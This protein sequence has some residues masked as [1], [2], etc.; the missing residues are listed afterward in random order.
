METCVACNGSGRL[1]REACPLC[2]GVIGWPDQDL[3][4]VMAAGGVPTIARGGMPAEGISL[5]SWNLLSPDTIGLATKEGPHYSHLTDEER[6][7][8]HRWPKILEEIRIADATVVCLQEI[9]KG[10]F[11]EIKEALA[12]FG[13][14]CVTHKKMQRNSLAIFFKPSFT[15]VWEV[16]PKIKGFEKTLAVGLEDA[17]RVIAVVICH[18]EGHPEKS[19]ERLAQLEKTFAEIKDLPHQAL[20]V[21][22]DFNAPLVEEDGGG[23][24]AVSSYMSRGSVPEGTTEWGHQ[25]SVSSEPPKPH[26]YALE[27]AYSPGPVFSIA[28]RSGGPALIDHIWYCQSLELVGVRDVFFKGDF[29]EE[30]LRHSLPSLRNPS[31]HLPL[32]VV[33]KWR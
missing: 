5:L 25:V 14:A 3:G 11:D 27:S 26:G 15:K 7:W 2:D 12:G 6:F 1:L 30:V 10:L 19:S 22:G 16:R 13:Y 17:G 18:I 21:A 28:L 20:I 24:T 33:L 4:H 32:G 9:N 29:R 31:D 8:E 23:Y